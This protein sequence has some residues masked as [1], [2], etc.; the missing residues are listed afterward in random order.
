MDLSLV[1]A[2]ERSSPHVRCLVAALL[3]GIATELALYVIVLERD[4]NR[5]ELQHAQE[6][7]QA[8]AAAA[9]PDVNRP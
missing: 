5:A 2:W 8:V 7:A 9:T 6:R 4:V 1:N 3:V